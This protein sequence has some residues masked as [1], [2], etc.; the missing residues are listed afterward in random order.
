MAK[1][2]L[3]MP[4]MGESIIEATILSWTKEVGDMVELDE[5]ILEI[6]TDKVDSEV[7]SPVEGKLIQ[8]LYKE[9]DVVPVG[10]VIAIIAA[11]GGEH[12]EVR[13]PLEAEEEEA[14][15]NGK[16]H[17]VETEESLAAQEV[18]FVPSTEPVLEKVGSSI[19]EN[20]FYS[21]L[22]LNIAKKEG[23][24]M[25]ELEALAGSGRGGRVT[26]KDILA[27]VNRRN[28]EGV[29]E[30][31]VKETEIFQVKP[32]KSAS[33]EEKITAAAAVQENDMEDIVNRIISEP[34]V[35]AVPEIMN[36]IGN[37][38][39]EVKAEPVEEKVI[40][41]PKAPEVPAKVMPP[42]NYEIVEMDRMRKL[43]AKN[44]LASTQTSA[45]VTSFVEADVTHIVQWRNRVKADFQSQYGEKLTFTPIFVQAVIKA[46]REHPM[47]NSSVH[48]DQILVKKDINIGIAVALPTDNLIVPVIKHA[49]RLNLAGL[50]AT[51]NDLANRA[52]NNKLK[53]E[54]LEGGTYTL[55]NVGTFGNVMGTPIIMQPQV[56]ILATGAI[57]KIPAVVE[58]P[59]GDVIAIRQKMFMSHS[60]D[61]RIIDGALGGRFVKRV[62]DILE[63]WDLNQNI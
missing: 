31:S 9:G 17:E 5:T 13:T 43:I 40:E 12:A 57:R 32:E 47:L 18:P 53:P 26:K 33:P 36:K 20:R 15:S 49:D 21:P 48:E 62:A 42:G 46:L 63:A 44:M 28:Y 4:K 39:E 14:P 38:E 7:P 61:H 37:S 23:M 16:A 10:A 35:E 8:Q 25:S 41:K 58:T 24:S 11:G 56:A 60:Y 59:T 34:Q 30:E 1:F 50:T 55:S 3:S 52:R 54:D 6:A 45:H 2:E 22:V 29:S 19:P 27:Y 51:I